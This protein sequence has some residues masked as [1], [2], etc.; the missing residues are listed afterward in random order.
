MG[1]VN[2]SSSDQGLQRDI[3]NRAVVPDGLNIVRMNF[4]HGSYEVA[5]PVTVMLEHRALPRI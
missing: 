5:M 3:A 4:S 2:V 1:S